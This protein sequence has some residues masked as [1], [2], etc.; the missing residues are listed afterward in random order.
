VVVRLVVVVVL[1]AL[2][3]VAVAAGGA[4]GYD[5]GGWLAAAW[6]L[7]VSRWV[8]CPGDFIFFVLG[9]NLY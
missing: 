2:A 8:R 7:A 4:G 5:V 3:V 1:V 6:G 9:N